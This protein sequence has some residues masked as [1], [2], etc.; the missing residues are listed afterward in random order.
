MPACFT[1]VRGEEGANIKKNIEELN[2]KSSRVF[3]GGGRRVEWSSLSKD[4]NRMRTFSNYIRF[5]CMFCMNI[6]QSVHPSQ[7]LKRNK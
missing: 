4:D 5:Y 1:G 7:R 3:F 6:E 2:G